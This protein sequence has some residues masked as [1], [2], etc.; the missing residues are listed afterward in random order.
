MKKQYPLIFICLLLTAV[1]S[2]A[3]YTISTVAGNGGTGSSGDGGPATAATMINPMGVAIDDTGNIFIASAMSIRKVRAATGIIT[4]VVGTGTSGFS[5]DGGPATA[6]KIGNARD[7][8]FD[9]SGNLYIADVL[10][11]RVRKVSSSGIITT[12]AGNGVPAFSGDGAAA[13]AAS[14]NSPSGIAV[15]AAGDLY[16]ADN[17]NNCIRKVSGGIIS[18]VAGNGTAANT[19]DGGPAT[20]ASLDHP[21]DLTFDISGNMLIA[22][23][24]NHSI[25]KVTPAGTISTVAG[26]GTSGYAGDGGPA[27][28][29]KMNTPTNLIVDAGGNLII[30]DWTNNCIRKVT[31]AGIITTVAGNNTPGFSGDGGPATAAM[32]KYPIGIALATTGEIYVAEQQNRRI[33]KLTPS[34]SFVQPFVA[35]PTLEMLVY[36]NPTSGALFIDRD[37][38]NYPTEITICDVTGRAIA[39]A[40]VT[41][42]H[43]QINLHSLSPGMYRIMTNTG[44][45]TTF[46]KQ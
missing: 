3:Q 23:G 12:V 44:K 10:Y 41:S 42:Q 32:M 16:I 22:D 15:D 28:A 1:V 9:A 37:G 13:T 34:P 4:T 38:L 27:T 5:G 18:T 8:A 31:T 40:V 11:H 29:G 17:Y 24:N 46:I 33:R 26:N 43:T 21:V 20:S 36:P 39:T 30:T 14:L 35:L 19:G 6:A 2:H 25:R 7:I 45:T